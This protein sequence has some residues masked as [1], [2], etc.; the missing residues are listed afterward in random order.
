MR[1]FVASPHCSGNAKVM[2]LI[3]G[4]VTET[5]TTDNVDPARSVRPLLPNGEWVSTSE[6]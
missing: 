6:K 3:I 1:S 2:I 5:I 4:A